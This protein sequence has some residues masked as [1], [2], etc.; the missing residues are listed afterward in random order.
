MSQT[1]E[2]LL[3]ARPVAEADVDTRARFIVRTY[4]HLV[5][6]VGA[7]TGL[8][9]LYF[10][11]GLAASI[12]NALRSVP[13]LL[14][15]GGFV[16]VSWMASSI[17]H[18]AVSVAAHYAALAAFVVVESIIFVPLLV[19]AQMKAPGVI[20]SAAVVTGLGFAGLTAVVFMTRKNFSFLG[21][22]LWWGGIAALV[23]IAAGAIFGFELGTW[24]S[25]GM[26]VFAGGAIL[27]DTSNVLRE[28]P[29]DRHVAASLQLFAS[30]MLLLWYVLRLFMS[31]K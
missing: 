13:W 11:T 17:A 8:E 5:G 23:A 16:L 30:V 4:G 9:I 6:A 7:F 29:E 28:Y 15:L 10:N 3:D 31:R 27:Y 25:V 19:L 21:S 14:V 20:T 22:I 26:I 12:F 2:L 1:A 18:K 24:F